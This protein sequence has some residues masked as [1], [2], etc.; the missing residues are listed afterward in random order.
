MAWQH[1][2]EPVEWVAELERCIMEICTMGPDF[3]VCNG[4]ITNGKERDYTIAMNVLYSHC[5][6][7]L[8]FTMGNHEYYGFYEDVG[9]SSFHAQHRFLRHTG[10][11]AIY[12]EVKHDGVQF[13]FLSTELYTPDMNDA[14]W[15][16]PRQLAW[17]DEKLRAADGPAI[18]FF[19]Q[20]V[21]NT[22]A[23]SIGT[24]I[25]SAELQ[26]ILSQ[27]S[28]VFFF[29]GHTHCRMDRD[30]QLIERSGVRYVGG[31]CLCGENPQSRWVDVY[32]NRIV[33]KLYDH[34]K[35][36]W[37]TDYEQTFHH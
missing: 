34:T 11:V 23:D 18:V 14:G 24:C 21:N 1:T 5:G 13:L 35:S 9:F 37:L 25:Q 33:I 22:V 10:H 8:Y 31:G 4:D 27:R 3:L 19:H 17:L 36:E 20:P 16:S 28:D 15:L 32:K 6:F 29:S 30:D 2:N 26:R 12:Y 7:P